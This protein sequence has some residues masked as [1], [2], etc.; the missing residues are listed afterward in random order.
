MQRKSFPGI[1]VGYLVALL[2]GLSQPSIAET[3]IAESLIKGI[4][5]GPGVE[6]PQFMI[7]TGE[8][9]SL[10]GRGLDEFL[11]GQRLRLTGHVAR[12]SNCM[13][14]QTFIVATVEVVEGEI[15]N[16]G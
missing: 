7:D 12:A 13:Q 8:Q 15:E 10:T 6:C 16:G 14:G 11:P 1:S 5:L 2:V 3:I 9:V 4:Y